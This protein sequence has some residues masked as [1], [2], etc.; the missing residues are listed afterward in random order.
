MEWGKAEYQLHRLGATGTSR[1][2][3]IGGSGREIRAVTELDRSSGVKL[4]THS[5]GFGG[6]VTETEVA[7]RAQ[8]PGQDMT[9]VAPCKLYSRQ[10]HDPALVV[11]AVFPTEGDRVLIV[12]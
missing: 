5:I 10:G 12:P 9:Q 2:A 4:D 6:G 3:T 11:V 8:A 7:D 1:A